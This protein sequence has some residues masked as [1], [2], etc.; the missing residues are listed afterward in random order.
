MTEPDPKTALR[1]FREAP[2][3]FYAL[4]L[5]RRSKSIARKRSSSAYK[6]KY[7]LPRLIEK[8]NTPGIDPGALR[9]GESQGE[10][11]SFLRPG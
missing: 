5:V 11:K 1:E 10:V 8:E 4:R 2:L 3:K 9:G 6:R 7:F